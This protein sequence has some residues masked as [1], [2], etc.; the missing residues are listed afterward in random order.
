MTSNGTH[1]AAQRPL[2]SV[3]IVSTNEI[4]HLR[5]CL[6]TVTAQTYPNYEVIVVDNASGDGSPDYIRGT[7]PNVRI[8]DTGGNLGYP[9][10]N[11]AGFDVARGEYLA[12]LN[13]DTT[14]APDW[15]EELVTALE[16]HPEAAM[17]T[18]KIL[19]I[20]EPSVINAAGNLVSITG[21]T[22]CRGVGEP[23]AGFS[24]IEEVPA[25]SGAA[26]LIR[27]EVVDEIGPFDPE[28]VAYLEET[29]LSLRARLTGRTCILAPSSRVFHQYSFRFSEWKCFHLEK[30]RYYMLMKV[31][32]VKTLLL[33]S[34]V[35]LASEALVWVYMIRMGRSHIRQKLR[36][37]VWIWQHRQLIRTRRREVQQLRKISDSELL[38]VFTP[39]LVFHQMVQRRL[40]GVLDHLTTPLFSAWARVVVRFAP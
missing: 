20:D 7:F 23:D 40:A 1:A 18:S 34:P 4:H 28:F 17:A 32:E 22:F 16:A 2:V 6:P 10:A 11:N 15:L 36:S 38:G 9:G 39:Y 8:V 12:V 14:V 19:L 30:N 35:L 31:L 29:D 25:V 24:V 3:I 33:L 26:F 13:P 5:R 21:L 27:R 37:Y